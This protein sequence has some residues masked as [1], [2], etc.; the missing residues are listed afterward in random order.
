ME[1]LS[2]LSSLFRSG[3]KNGMT[4]SKKIV[5]V[6]SVHSKPN[7]EVSEENPAISCY[8]NCRLVNKCLID[9]G[10]AVNVIIIDYLEKLGFD[11]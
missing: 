8:I 10:S 5:K 6:N 3:C 7:L 11:R 9:S 1:E 2:D 4:K